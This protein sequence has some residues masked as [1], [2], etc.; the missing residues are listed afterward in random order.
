MQNW[1]LKNHLLKMTFASCLTDSPK[2]FLPLN[3]FCIRWWRYFSWWCKPMP[4]G[5]YLKK[6]YFGKLMPWDKSLAPDRG[7]CL[8]CWS[9]WVQNSTF[10]SPGLSANFEIELLSWSDCSVNWLKRVFHWSNSA[11]KISNDMN[12]PNLFKQTHAILLTHS[13]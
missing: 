11:S 8:N 3:F 12:N 13:K 1:M 9:N 5:W 6:I 4:S 2:S 10:Y 7:P